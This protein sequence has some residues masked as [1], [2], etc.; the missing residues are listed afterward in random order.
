M[1]LDLP[2]DD[3]DTNTNSNDGQDHRHHDGCD[4]GQNTCIQTYMSNS[5]TTYK[6]TYVMTKTHT[7]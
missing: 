3:E 6:Y 7:Y 4:T 2:G 1:K 5:L